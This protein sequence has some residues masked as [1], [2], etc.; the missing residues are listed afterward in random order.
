MVFY[1]LADKSLDAVIEF[2]ASEDQATRDLATILRDEPDWES[3]LS[4]VRVEYARGR[5]QLIHSA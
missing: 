1:G 4:V 3:I 2:Y 5:F